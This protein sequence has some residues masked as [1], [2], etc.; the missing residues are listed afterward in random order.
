MLECYLRCMVSQ[1][2]N[3]W[4]SWLALAEWWYNTHHHSGLKTT[5]FEALYGYPPPH[6]N[7]HQYG[8]QDP[9]IKAFCRDITQFLQLL[10]QNLTATQSRIKHYADKGKSERT[11][12]VGDLVYLRIK[13]YKQHTLTH[14]RLGK[15]L[16]KYYRPFPIEENIGTVTYRLSLP[17]EAKV[18]PVFH[19]CLLKKKIGQNCPNSPNSSSN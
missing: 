9:S 19:V 8:V 6:L 14:M 3:S 7:F 5:P 1:R 12:E 13:P 4:L 16:P 11:F 10:R 18:H 15:L 2:P 17:V